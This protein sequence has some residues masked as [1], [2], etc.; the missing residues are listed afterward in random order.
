MLRAIGLNDEMAHSSLRI[1]IG[2]FTTV[3]EVDYS[4][5]KIREAVGKLRESSPQWDIYKESVAL[6]QVKRAAR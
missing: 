2:R 3:E 4:I 5:G 6:N 1:S